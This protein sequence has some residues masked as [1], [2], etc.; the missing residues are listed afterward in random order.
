MVE[1]AARRR[2]GS[3]PAC[4]TGS[5][6]RPRAT[7]SSPSSCSA[8]SSTRALLEQPRRR[9]GARPATARRDPRPADDPGAARRAARHARER[10]ALGDR[11]GLGRRLRLRRG[12][13]LGARAARR[14]AARDDGA[15]DAR[16]RSTSSVRV[17]DG[18]EG[19]HRFQHIMIRDT[20]YDGILKRARAD[21]HERFVAW[22]DGRQPRPRR[23][24]RGD[25]RLPPR[26]GLDVPLRAR[27]ARRPRPRD[28]RGRAR[29]GSR[30]R[31]GA[32]SRAA[33]SPAPRR[34]SAA[35]R[36]SCPSSTAS[37]CGCFPST[38]RRS[39]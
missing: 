27:A 24:V 22:A 34:C 5:S 18:D 10:R 11:A 13:R 33:T 4:S 37:G 29:G 30:R 38:A 17:E 9:R 36:H 7:R 35:P 19:A 31:A 6:T 3:T 15:R 8:C 26:A 21:L 12:R 20:A 1:S 25:P 14:L 23:R 2:H 39:S 16:R 28:R 32:R